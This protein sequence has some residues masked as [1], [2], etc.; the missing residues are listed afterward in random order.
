MEIKCKKKENISK[1]LIVVC[2][3]LL[4]LIIVLP[5]KKSSSKYMNV[6]GEKDM[7][8]T[9]SEVAY[10]ESRLK[11]ILENT[12]GTGTMDVMIHMTSKSNDNMFYS[13]DTK[14]YQVDGVLVVAHVKESQAVSD[15]TFAV[16]A[17]FDLPAHKV[18]VLIKK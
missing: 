11:E 5:V 3:G 12:Y 1:L 6:D 10:Y 4:L 8:S 9:E 16:C 14:Q 7:E 13:D 2:I 15:I 18:A 17:L